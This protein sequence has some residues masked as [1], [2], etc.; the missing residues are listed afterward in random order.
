M[1]KYLTVDIGHLLIDGAHGSFLSH[2]EISRFPAQ[3][4]ECFSAFQ[5]SMIQPESPLMLTLNEERS[6]AAVRTAAENLKARYENILILGIGGSSLGARA[7][8]QFLCGPYHLLDHQNGPRI[9]FLDNVD[10]VWVKHLETMLDMS[11]TG[12]VYIS[13]SGSTPETAGNFIY[14]YNKYLAAGGSPEDITVICDESDNGASRAARRMDCQMLSIP[15]GLPGRYSVLSSVGFLPAELAGID[16]A[17]L[18]KGARSVQQSILKTPLSENALFLLGTALFDLSRRGKSMHVMFNYSS[19]LTDF[20]LWF[21]QLWAESLGKEVN[22]AGEKV[23][24][25]TTPLS[26][27]GA[28]DQHSLLQLFK[29]G[30]ADKAFGFIKVADMGEPK[31]FPALFTDLKEYGYFAGHTIQEQLHVEQRSTEMSLVRTGHP[32][33]RITLADISPESLGA[34]F[35]F[36]EALTVFTGALLQINPFNQPGVEEGKVTTY[37][38]MGRSDFKDQLIQ[39]IEQVKAFDEANRIYKV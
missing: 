38:L 37:T 24:T 23:H 19:L 4:G 29:E 31:E 5:Q 6:L 32:C 27:V 33:Y 36:Y 25:G 8:L 35:Y 2:D 11:R 13:K 18:L 21:M 34:L 3:Y 16:S 26:C 12:L 17:A 22:L 28:T 39:Q 20:G 30:P 15:P 7:M 14:F 9:F 10:P 1:Q